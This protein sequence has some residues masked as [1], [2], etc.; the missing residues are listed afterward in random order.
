MQYRHAIVPGGSFF[1]TLATDRRRPVWAS[2]Q[3]I[4]VKRFYS[5]YGC[6]VKAGF[7]APVEA[8]QCAL[9]RLARLQNLYQL[10]KVT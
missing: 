7:H 6:Y 8:T 3:A 10:N 1:F 4:D 2:D 5:N 9:E